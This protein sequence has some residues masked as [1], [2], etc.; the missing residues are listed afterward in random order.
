MHGSGKRS[1]LP[2]MGI[3]YGVRKVL[4]S[5]GKSAA[6]ESMYGRQASWLNLPIYSVNLSDLLSLRGTPSGESGVN[7]PLQSTS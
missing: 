7:N 4:G 2:I 1:P 6:L 3:G 5:L